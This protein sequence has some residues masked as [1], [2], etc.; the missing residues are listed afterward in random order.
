MKKIVFLLACIAAF[1]FV[2]DIQGQVIRLNPNQAY[3]SYTG[4]AGDTASA[5]TAKTFD[6]FVN[7]TAMY[8]YDVQ[9]SIDSAGD[10]SDFTLQ[11]QGSNDETN[12][13]NVGSSQTWYVSTSDTVVRFSNSPSSEAWVVAAH[14]RTTAATNDYHAFDSATGVSTTWVDTTTI[15]ARVETVAEQTY[16]ITKQYPV[17][18]RYLRLSATGGGADAKCELELLTVAIRED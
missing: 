5:T 9:A 8:Y 7:K 14:T 3:E 17:G 4:V 12:F 2:A 11:L 1:V 16:T 6:I 15:A 10:G 13:Y 18:W